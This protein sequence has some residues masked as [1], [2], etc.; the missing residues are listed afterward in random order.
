MA[1]GRQVSAAVIVSLICKRRKRK[2]KTKEVW[3]KEWLRRRTERKRGF[4]AVVRRAETGGRGE[5]PKIL[6]ARN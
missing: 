3:E 5:L 4:Q 1:D 2:R 6:A